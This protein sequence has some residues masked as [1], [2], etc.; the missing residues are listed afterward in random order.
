MA[1]FK[2]GQESGILTRTGAFVIATARR[3]EVLEELAAKGMATLPLDVTDK[4][5]I[6]Q[7]KED[8]AKLTSGCLDVLVNNAYVCSPQ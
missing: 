7:C 6:A 1:V 5:S 3:L 4:A 8:V 2:H